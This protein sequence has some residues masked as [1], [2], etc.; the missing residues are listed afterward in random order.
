MKIIKL[1]IVNKLYCLPIYYIGIKIKNIIII[2]D[3]FFYN[4]I[5]CIHIFCTRVH[6]T[7][8]IIN[9]QMKNVFF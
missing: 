7:V 9:K 5:K 1:L 4:G 8:C 2:I 6:I 3:N